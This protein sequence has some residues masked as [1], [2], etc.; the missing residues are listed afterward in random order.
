MTV[1]SQAS[2]ATTAFSAGLQ[3]QGG[4]SIRSTVQAKVP[5]GKVTMRTGAHAGK[6]F[7]LNWDSHQVLNGHTILVGGSGTGKTHQLRRIISHLAAAGLRV[8]LL[9]V[10]SDVMPDCP[11]HT[12]RFSES[13][14]FGLNPLE[15][16]EDP[17]FGGPRK[18]ANAFINLMMR[19]SAL[20]EKQKGALFRLLIDMYRRYGFYMEDAATWSLS[21]DPRTWAKVAKRQ[22]TLTDLTKAVWEKC[23]SLKLGVSG[24]ATR[25]FEEVAKCQKKLHSLRLKNAA[26]DEVEDALAKAKTN[27]LTAIQEALDKM[28][29][30]DELEE[31]I[32]WDSF[33][34][35]KGLHD[36]LVGLE[37]SGI[38]KGRAPAFDPKVPVWRYDI[39]P[40]SREESQF[41]VDCLAAQ[42]F[43]AAKQRGEADGPDTALVIDEASIFM[44]KD[45]DHIL[46]IIAREARKFGVMLVLAT[47]EINTFPP[48]VISSAATKIILGVD[49]RFHKATEAA[50]GMETGKLK[51]IQPQKTALV[52][53]KN[54]GR[55]EGLS[56]RFHEVELS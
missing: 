6:T 50:F 8:H 48:A 34:V 43:A 20:G 29:T 47:Q 24:S 46:N 14:E 35:V 36:R 39:A 45:S 2:S 53:I 13:T 51:F 19:Q 25:K 5:L 42:I 1:N 52:Q 26:G 33:D 18:K 9:D 11:T 31:L 3:H 15:V 4:R 37:R 41:F 22:P 32:A 23:V 55:A 28:D 38:F 56:N 27:F 16:S 12:I 30:G 21:R 40:L 54:K 7:G 49:E 44:D 10:H 17:D